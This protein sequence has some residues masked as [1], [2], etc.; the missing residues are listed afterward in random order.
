V[1]H[2]KDGF[3]ENS[4]SKSILRVIVHELVQKFKNVHYF[5]A[6]EIVTDD[7]RDYRFYSEDMVHPN[8]SSIRYIFNHFSNCFF[9]FE[10]TELLSKI[11]KIVKAKEHIPFSENTKSYKEFK[12]GIYQELKLLSQ[13]Y[14]FIDFNE[15]MNLFI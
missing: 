5:P 4:L 15:E 13:K 7:L 12:L 14:S 10:T 3:P 9:D 1:R 11:K 6:F 8:E 2:I